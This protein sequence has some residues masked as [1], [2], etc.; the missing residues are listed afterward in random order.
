MSKSMQQI[1]P[2]HVNCIHIRQAEL[3][4]L[5]DVFSK[6]RCSVLAVEEGT[7]HFTASY[8]IVAIEPLAEPLTQERVEQVMAVVGRYILTPRIFTIWNQCRRA[9][10]VICS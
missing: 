7:R 4:G 3:L 8:D 10:A 2:K 9:L 1:E 6:Y 5:G